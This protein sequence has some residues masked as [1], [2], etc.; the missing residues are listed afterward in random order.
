MLPAKQA[1]DEA[2]TQALL[3]QSAGGPDV[4][5]PEVLRAQSKPESVVVG[6]SAQQMDET[7]SMTPAGTGAVMTGPHSTGN[8]MSPATM[9]ALFQNWA[10]MGRQTASAHLPKGFQ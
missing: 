4:D 9:L 1:P 5:L 3:A 10:A 7:W 8:R 6:R 2:G